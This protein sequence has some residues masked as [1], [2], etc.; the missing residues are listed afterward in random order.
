MMTPEF[1]SST[2]GRYSRNIRLPVDI[3]KPRSRIDILSISREVA[4]RWMITTKSHWILFNIGSGNGLLPTAP[5]HY[6]NQ[7]WPSS[8]RTTYVTRPQR[9]KLSVHNLPWHVP[10][11]V[12]RQPGKEITA[13]NTSY[14][15]MFPMIL[16]SAFVFYMLQYYYLTLMW[17][18][19]LELA[20][21]E[22]N[23]CCIK[24]QV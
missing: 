16:G 7:C 5:S 21:K 24:Y 18:R 8:T 10:E 11:Y 2:I 23:V 3:F 19:L 15:E 4:L 1:D 20:R 12:R 13:I 9:V 14:F 22:T 6:L 17:H